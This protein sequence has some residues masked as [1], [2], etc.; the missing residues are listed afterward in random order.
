VSEGS[1]IKPFESYSG[2]EGKS[3]EKVSQKDSREVKEAASKAKKAVG[4]I[5]SVGDMEV[6]EGVG[7]ISEIDSSRKEGGNQSGTISGMTYAQ[8]R[9]ALLERI[10]KEPEMRKQIESEIRKEIKYLHGKAMKMVGKKN[11]FFELN[12]VMKK[13]RELKG[14]LAMIAKAS[15]EALKSLWL[16]FVHGVM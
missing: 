5:E 10:P 6:A 7:E 12:N 2:P 8:V 11:T 1:Q 16:R 9:A 13:I 15:Y 3:P 4:D 14:I